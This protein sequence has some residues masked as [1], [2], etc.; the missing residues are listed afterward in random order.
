M[1]PSSLRPGLP[2]EA[3]LRQ[4]VERVRR[5]ALGYPE[6]T[7]EPLWE[8]PARFADGTV[9]GWRSWLVGI[10]RHFGP[11]LVSYNGFPRE[12]WPRGASS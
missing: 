2:I 4:R 10:S 3:P 11:R 5:V 7:T 1:T 12:S 8:P 6:A 9:R